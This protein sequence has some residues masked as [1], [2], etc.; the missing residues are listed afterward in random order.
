MDQTGHDL[1]RPPPAIFLA[2]GK[3]KVAAF[4]AAKQTRQYA[5]IG[6]PGAQEGVEEDVA[7]EWIPDFVHHP[8]D[9]RNRQSNCRRSRIITHMAESLAGLDAAGGSR[10]R[11]DV[12]V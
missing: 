2:C 7:F 12:C 4:C 6:G 9:S 1:R 3:L 10:E 5:N 8:V 11:G